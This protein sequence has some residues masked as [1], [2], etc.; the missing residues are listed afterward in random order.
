MTSE[1]NWFRPAIN[2]MQGYQPGEWPAPNA[3]V[4]KLNSN[5]NPYPPSPKVLDALAD[6]SPEL[7]RR[8]PDP[9]AADFC[10]VVGETFGIPTDWVIAGNGSDDLLTMLVRA[11][12]ENS[13]RSAAGKNVGKKERMLAYPMPTYVLYRTLAAIQ[14]AGTV[15]IP[16]EVKGDEWRL[17]VEKLIATQAAITLVATPNSPTGHVVPI[18]ELRSLAAGLNGVLVVDEAYIDFAGEGAPWASLALVR[19][20][21]NVIVLR[22]LSKGYGLAGLRVGFGCAQPPLLAGLRKVKDSY[23]VDAI[24]LK[25][26][27]VAIADQRYRGAI[28]QRVRGDREQLAADLRASKF[29]VWPSFANFLLVQPPHN[30][31]QRLYQGLKEKQIMIRYFNE[32]GLDDKL[33][34]TVGTPEQNARMV[35]AIKELL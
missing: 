10:R 35:S 8:Y 31:A 4:L 3:G 9:Q 2:R 18:E 33:R 24:A 20:F 11:C 19:E 12:A 22:T 32:P 27:A 1:A 6:F 28:A 16:Y 13:L 29:R 23:N 17:P 15:E 30:T 34:I 26:G 5:E 21:E 25:L 14:P 7:L